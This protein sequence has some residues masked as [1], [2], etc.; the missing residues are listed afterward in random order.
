MGVQ[1]KEHRKAT[2]RLN[3]CRF[4][5][6]EGVHYDG[7]STHAPV[8]NAGTIQI[9]LILMIMANW[10]GQIVDVKGAFLHGEFEDGKVIYMKVS[11]GIQKF[12]PDDVVLK[13]KKCIYGLKQAA[14][15][16]WRQL[17]LCMKSMEMMW[18]TADPCLYH[19]WGEEGLVLIVSWIEDNLIVGSKKGVEK[20]KKD[21]MERFDCKD[22]GD[23]EEYMGCKIARTKNLLMFTQPVLMQSYNDKFELPKKSYRTPAPAELVL[24]TGQKEEA[25]S[26]AMQKKY[27]SGTGKAMHVMHYSKPEMYIA[28]Q[29]LSRHMHKAMQ[30]H[31]KAMLRILKY[32]LDTDEQGLVLEPNRKWDGS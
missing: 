29:D 1:E 21:I 12:Y 22:C 9:V 18:S 17:L 16:S 27:C 31:F 19:K 25:L 5:Q 4:K 15:A 30:D 10:Q 28:V 3:A 20:T 7:K 11:C 23:I 32:S 24:V 14:M 8:T 6:V 13:L 2:G 26:Q